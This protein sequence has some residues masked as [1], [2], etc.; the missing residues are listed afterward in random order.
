MSSV[1]SIA[2]QAGVSITTVSRALN[3]DSTV[4]AKT[5]ELVLAIANRTGYVATMGR[6]VT[7]HLA[8]AYTGE[9]SLADPFDSAVLEGVMRGVDECR[10]DVVVLNMQRDK[11]PDETYTQFFMRKGVRGVILRTMEETRS[12]CLAIAKE[13]FPHFV[14]SERFDE[15]EVSYIDFDSKP[16]SIR[17]VKYLHALGHRRI[18][19]G[20]HITPDRDHEDRLTGYREALAACGLPYD[21][22]YV[23]RHQYTLTGGATAMKMAASMVDRPTAIY[24]ADPLLGVGAIKQA[25]EMGVRVPQDMSIVGFDDGDVRYGVHPTMTAVCQNAAELGF[26]ASLAL[27]RM[28]TGSLSAPIQKTLHTF[29][30]VHDSTGPPPARSDDPRVDGDGALRRLAREIGDRGQA[31]RNGSP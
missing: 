6:R 22:R 12:I 31:E 18:A 10:F 25:H 8:F 29:F 27:T 21:E 19:F 2:E 20:V 11:K 24:F 16:D 1:R 13:G 26:E 7:T 5:R 14:I 28:L 4:S 15:P 17:A 9:S 3:N 30:E 23:L